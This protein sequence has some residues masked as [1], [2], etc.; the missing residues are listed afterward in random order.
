MTRSLSLIH[1]LL[2]LML[3]QFFQKYI[4]LN[5]EKKGNAYIT[6]L[7]CIQQWTAVMLVDDD[8]DNDDD[9][10]CFFFFGGGGGEWQDPFECIQHDDL[11]MLDDV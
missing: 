8:D 2:P 9:Y 6:L 4:K 5:L 3:A 1:P 7:H 10:Y 11:T